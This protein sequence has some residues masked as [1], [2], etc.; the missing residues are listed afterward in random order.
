M[1]YDR[2]GSLNR[3]KNVSRLVKSKREMNQNAVSCID[4]YGFCVLFERMRKF[5]KGFPFLY[6]PRDK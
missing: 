3:E 2:V 4:K 5:D 1:K 6:L